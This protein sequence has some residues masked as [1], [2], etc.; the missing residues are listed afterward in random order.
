MRRFLI[1]LGVSLLMVITLLV[2]SSLVAMSLQLVTIDEVVGFLNNIYASRDFRVILGISGFVLAILGFVIFQWVTL[3]L[4]RE[5]TIAFTTPDGQV[6]VSLEAIGNF[7]RRVTGSLPGVKEI[8]P[9]VVANR[10]GLQ[11]FAKVILLEETNIPDISEEIQRLVR[12][13][14]QDMLGIEENIQTR[15]HIV[16]IVSKEGEGKKEGEG[17]PFTEPITPY[18]DYP[19]E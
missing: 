16:K 15:V 3:K 13:K 18:R 19:E 17:V 4:Q 2:G 10:K 8:K 1:G 7:I 5:K 12:K 14:I 9:D 6:T 11:V